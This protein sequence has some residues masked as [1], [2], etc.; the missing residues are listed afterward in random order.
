VH[1]FDALGWKESERVA[2]GDPAE[3]GLVV[4]VDE[5]LVGVLTCYDLRFPELAR[6]LV[7]N[8]ATAIAVPAAWVAGPGKVAQWRTLLQARAIENTVYAVAADQ[9]SPGFSGHSM[10]VEPSG[11]LLDE[12]GSG[13]DAATA[14]ADLDLGVVDRVRK[15]LPV[16]EHRR[17]DVSPRAATATLGPSLRRAE[18]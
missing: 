6:V 16:L 7:D 4:P 12:L 9:S 3:A 17:F 13:P 8:G 18:R 2:P 15:A 1:H 11:D 5:F 10:I 14:L